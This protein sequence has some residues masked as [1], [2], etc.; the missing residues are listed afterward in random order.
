MLDHKDNPARDIPVLPRSLRWVEPLRATDTSLSSYSSLPPPCTSHVIPLPCTGLSHRQDH[1]NFRAEPARMSYE[2]FEADK[3]LLE[4]HSQRRSTAV[5]TISCQNTDTVVRKVTDTIESAYQ[6][7]AS[8]ALGASTGN[9]NLI[10]Q[11]LYPIVTRPP[12]LLQTPNF[13]YLIYKRLR[14][15]YQTE[16]IHSTSTTYPFM[17]SARLVIYEALQKGED[18]LPIAPSPIPSHSQHHP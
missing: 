3:R 13:D 18:F 12:D 2:R 4:I 15:L 8:F 10:S 17:T 14:I 11:T 1:N 7:A 9:E 16:Y 5:S 6:N